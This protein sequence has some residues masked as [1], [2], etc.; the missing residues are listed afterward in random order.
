MP[1]ISLCLITRD[2]EQM[3]PACLASVKGVVDEVVVVDTGST[4]RTVELAR[5][6]GAVVASRPWTGFADARNA[7]L[8]LATGGWVLVLDADERLLPG[9]GRALR[10]HAGKNSA[11]LGFLRLHNAR[12]LDSP[13]AEVLSGRA[14]LGDPLWL[15][16][17]LKRTPDLRY[18]GVVH[19][20]VDGWFA[21]RK[22]K[23]ARLE[24]DV[25]HLGEVAE[26]RQQR[27][28][29]Q[30]NIGL[31]R[32]RCRVEAESITPFGYL[33]LELAQRGEPEEG[34]AVAERGWSLLPSQ[35][36]WRRYQR[37]AVARA[38]LA[39]VRGEPAL[40]LEAVLI[41]ERHDGACADLHLLRGWALELRA[42]ALDL[43]SAR[44]AATLEEAEASLRAALALQG[45]ALTESCVVGATQWMG[46][47]RLGAVQLLQG[48]PAEA[49][50]SFEQALSTQPTFAEARLG[51]VEVLLAQGDAA[52]ALAGAGDLVGEMADAWALASAAAA[53]L[54]ASA[55]AEGFLAQALGSPQPWVS[56]VWR[57]RAEAGRAGRT[58]D[59]PAA[60][61]V[62]EPRRWAVTVVSPP[63][64]GF[65]AAFAE[66]AETLVHGLRALGDDA[67]LSTDPGLPGRRHLVLG[68]N[69]VPPTKTKLADGSILYNLEQI[70]EGSPWITR[71]LL[72]LYRRFPL[73]DY[74]E[75]NA[76]ALVALGLPRP[77][78]VPI[79]YAPS[80]TR[81]A[82][83]DVEDIDVLF[84]GELNERRE[85]VLRALAGRG[86]SVHWAHRVYGAE[87]DA[88]IARSKLVLNLHYYQAKV[89]EVVRVSYLLANRRAVV[90][91][92]GCNPVEEAPFEEG[93][94]FASYGELV[95]RC[96]ALLADPAERDWLAAAGQRVMQGRPIEG[97]LRRALSLTQ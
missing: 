36:W 87:R 68:T 31:L 34:W 72:D 2:E 77:A 54:G 56:A 52:G 13:A 18:E 4:D 81:I 26:L 12:A 65:S 7:A 44:R 79:G 64:Y 8:E 86:A 83:A 50:R 25:L 33:A 89:F 90:S 5:A 92:R 23:A 19:E 57:A 1:K 88:L 91:E 58:G 35:P 75:A 20:S 15:P 21:T 70:Q 42:A 60:A 14:R 53:A 94:A 59:H 9:A 32:E 6:A 10:A 97:Y 16:R 55:D 30:R 93:V 11:P 43:G 40:A 17:L 24:A 95:E 80:L 47:A 84:Y 69:L 73:W 76:D 38:L 3:L 37:L 96:L 51:R 62:H 63:G 67:V 27:G 61:L 29:A 82:P 45:R 39:L 41:A 74:S 46:W 22:F 28:K 71:E 78:V 85:A 48:K 66:V 49:G